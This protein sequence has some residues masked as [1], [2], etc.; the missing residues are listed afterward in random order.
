MFIKVTQ[1]ESEKCVRCWHHRED[2]GSNNEH[3][4]LCSRCVENVTGD[5]EE[6]KYA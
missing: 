1:S 3:S 2:I 6:R 5:G 4:E